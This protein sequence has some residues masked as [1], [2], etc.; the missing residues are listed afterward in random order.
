MVDEG[1][2]ELTYPDTPRHPISTRGSRRS[3]LGKPRRAT[4]PS[5]SS[6]KTTL[7]WYRENTSKSNFQKKRS[8]WRAI[9]TF[10]EATGSSIVTKKIG[11]IRPSEI[12]EFASWLSNR[13]K[14]DGSFYYSK[15]SVKGY[16]ALVRSFFKNWAA[17]KGKQNPA[18]PE[19]IK[20][21]TARLGGLE[22]TEKVPGAQCRSIGKARAGHR[23]RH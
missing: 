22:K 11:E 15:S 2:L 12:V 13:K 23:E 17:E 18:S 10:A 16:F 19:L 9:K 14:K 21:D 7:E 5:K 4:I 1:R 3:R 20:T 8:S 6:W